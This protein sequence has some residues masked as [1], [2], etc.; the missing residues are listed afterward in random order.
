[1]TPKT[2]W[3]LCGAV[4]GAALVGAWALVLYAGLGAPPP[5]GPTALNPAP[6]QP[7]RGNHEQPPAN[8]VNTPAIPGQANLPFGNSGGQTAG[9]AAVPNFGNPGGAGLPRTA[10]HGNKPWPWPGRGI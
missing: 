8:P 9:Q 1:M 5:V 10:N 3:L 4:V 2:Q 7:N 6:P